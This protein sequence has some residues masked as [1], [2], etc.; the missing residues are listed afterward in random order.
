MDI[1]ASVILP[2]P[3]KEQL[4]LADLVVDG[5]V[6]GRKSRKVNSEN[7]VVTDLKVQVL[8]ES[9][10]SK[11]DEN[12]FITIVVPGGEFWG[13]VHR[14]DGVPILSNGDRGIFLL[15]EGQSSYYL[16]SLGL[17]V[18][19]IKNGKIEN[20]LY[21]SEYSIDY[22]SMFS[23]NNLATATPIQTKGAKSRRV[24]SSFA[25]TD[26]QMHENSNASMIILILL[27]LV[28]LVV[29]AVITR[30]G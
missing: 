17:S 24:I 27:M 10:P 22:T 12:N 5:S 23:L 1:G 21:P 9:R 11:R 6:M 29:H 20:Y 16:S 18:Y 19:L 3:L 30:K 15:K 7:R 14:V 2:M 13:E 4:A 28:F 8:R 26:G 25:A